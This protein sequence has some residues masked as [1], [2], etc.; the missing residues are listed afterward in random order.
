V[1]LEVNHSEDTVNNIS[2]ST[3]TEYDNES[4]EL[5]HIES[6]GP[7]KIDPEKDIKKQSH[8]SQTDSEKCPS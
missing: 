7:E 3:T 1:P 4:I 5:E 8:D 6:I 2:E